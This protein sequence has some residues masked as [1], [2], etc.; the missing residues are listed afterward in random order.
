MSTYDCTVFQLHESAFWENFI[1]DALDD[2]VRVGSVSVEELTSWTIHPAAELGFIVCCLETEA[3]IEAFVSAIRSARAKGGELSCL[4]LVKTCELAGSLDV[5]S[6]FDSFVCTQWKSASDL[7][8]RAYKDHSTRIQN[9]AMKAFLN[10][11]VDGY[12][13]WDIKWD[14]V[15]WSDRM[16]EIVGIDPKNS[17][18]IMAD[19]REMIHPLDRDRV[20]QNIKNHIH[21]H[22][23][24]TNIEMRLKRGDGS[25]G[26]YIAN[27]T[28]LRNN[29]GKPTL[30]VGSLTDQT[31]MQLVEQ[32]LLDTQK[33]FT[34]LFHEMN[35]AAVLADIDSGIILEANQPAERL[36]GKPISQLV[37]SHQSDLHPPLMND[38]ARQAFSDHIAALMQ[39]RRASIHFPIVRAD[40]VIVPTEISS[41]LIDLE[42]TTRL[43]GVFRDISE[44]IKAEQEIRE[45]DA[46]IQLSSH[47]ASM[48]TL[49]AGVAHEINNP[50][51]YVLGNLEVM[52]NIVNS[53]E[54]DA[55]ECNEVIDTAL[56]G[57]RYVREIVSDLKSISDSNEEKDSSDPRDVIRIASRM[58]MSDLRHRAKLDI[59][60][61]GRAR[62]RLSPARLS[63]VVLN[64]FSNA[65]R[66]FE[67]EDRTKNKI[68]VRVYDEGDTVHIRIEDNGKGIS[69]E[70]LERIWE[71]FFTKNA[72]SGGTGLGL[73]ICRRILRDVGGDIS[74]S[75]ELGEGTKVFIAIPVSPDSILEEEAPVVKDDEQNLQD[76]KPELF[77]V[78]DDKLVLNLAARMLKDECDIRIFSNAEEALSQFEQ[79]ERPDVILSDIMMPE[80]DGITFYEEMCAQGADEASFLFMTG[81]AVTKRAMA[82]EQ[83]M[84][85]NDR[86]LQKPFQSEDIRRAVKGAFCQQNRKQHKTDTTMQKQSS[87]LLKLN[88][89]THNELSEILG[90][91]ELLNQYKTL[92]QQ[93]QEFHASSEGLQLA[94][95]ANGAHKVA[96]GAGMLGFSA[97]SD[98]LRSCQ[99]EASDGNDLRAR[100]LARS[101]ATVLPELEGVITS[102]R[103]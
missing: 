7:L 81:G 52:K 98:T 24:Y 54:I 4:L 40:G 23:P 47:L 65:A 59:Q 30:M 56:T 14:F 101:L 78:D 16:C 22:I 43:L 42:G 82:F 20:E 28:T 77:I 96:G 85:N 12:W 90:L 6:D 75:S 86:V 62:V 45:R 21:Q 68:K 89:D 35:D 97:L 15:E 19:F 8:S 37:G 44:R 58:A 53:D 79:G 34:V 13:I 83:K 50:L 70:D 48:G 5:S 26:Y 46:Q 94:E 73:S 61:D 18:K 38:E 100:E 3:D 99:R 1:K 103:Q 71:P 91:D 69:Q 92:H 63:Q 29:R 60:L 74:I 41:S 27:G 93:L 55:S 49:A 51:T 2:T 72:V 25:F 76:H 39:N 64:T 33:R 9:R 66:A 95:L 80:M 57:A 102:Y 36:W 31:S 67:T 11:S 17:P 84:S 87:T 88:Q 10:H 32:K